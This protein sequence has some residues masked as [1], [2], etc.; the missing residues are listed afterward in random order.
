MTVRRAKQFMPFASLKGY[1][2]YIKEQ[3]RIKE[4]R[5]ELSEDQAEELSAALS[6][7]SI[8][9]MVKVTH[10]CTDH[11]E[12]TQGVLTELDKTFRYLVIVS[13]KIWIDDIVSVFS[14]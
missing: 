11:Y 4:P 1:Y 8:G 10:Y 5:K 7:L 13:R 6:S 9:D 2:D 14:L 12:T 3:E